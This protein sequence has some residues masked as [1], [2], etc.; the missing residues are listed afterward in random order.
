MTTFKQP[1]VL[2]NYLTDTAN[3][4]KGLER[5]DGRVKGLTGRAFRKR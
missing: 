1:R 4:H 2:D 5:R 3:S